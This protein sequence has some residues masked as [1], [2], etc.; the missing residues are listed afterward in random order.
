MSMIIH[1]NSIFLPWYVVA[2]LRKEYDIV[3]RPFLLYLLPCEHM[4]L[5]LYCWYWCT[6]LLFLFRLGYHDW[7]PNWLLSRLI[8][9]KYRCW[10]SLVVTTCGFNF[11]ALNSL[12]LIKFA[13]KHHFLSCTNIWC[14][15]TTRCRSSPGCI[16]GWC[17]MHD[18]WLEGGLLLRPWVF[19]KFVVPPLSPL[20]A[21]GYNTTAICRWMCM[22]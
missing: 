21:L 9:V 15:L 20:Y 6:L 16:G 2:Y 3:F 14:V 4:L 22:L 7:D 8:V 18:S 17:L 19:G 1:L 5:M 11:L 13:M 12:L 10:V